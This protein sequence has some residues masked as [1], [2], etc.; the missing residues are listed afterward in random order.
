MYF[1]GFLYAKHISRTF[2]EEVAL[3][4]K[5]LA[6]LTVFVPERKS[7]PVLPLSRLC[8]VQL[9]RAFRLLHFE[10]IQDGAQV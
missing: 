6:D 8:C 4:M 10:H 9:E 7:S 3:Q 2:P 1:L 5:S